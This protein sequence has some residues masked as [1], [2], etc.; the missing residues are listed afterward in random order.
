M[1]KRIGT[2]SVLADGLF[3]EYFY[4]GDEFILCNFGGLANLAE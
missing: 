4:N 1:S 2:E 3:K